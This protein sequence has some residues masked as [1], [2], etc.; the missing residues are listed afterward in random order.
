MP[1]SIGIRCGVKITD[2]GFPAMSDKRLLDLRRVAVRAD[3]VGRYALVAF[4]EVEVQLRRAPAARHARL[5][6]DHDGRQLDQPFRDERRKA[7]DR[8][9]RIAAG[10]GD[11]PGAARWRSP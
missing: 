3:R 11:E 6:I 7:E 4:R 5:A 8:R 2:T 9:L 1:R 10:V